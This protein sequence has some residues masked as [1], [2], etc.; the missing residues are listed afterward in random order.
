MCGKR[1]LGTV[2]EGVLCSSVHDKQLR[3]KC[4][5]TQLVCRK[6]VLRVVLVAME[7]VGGVGS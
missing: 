3:N 7:L 1:E 5:S 2:R 4:G 6:Q